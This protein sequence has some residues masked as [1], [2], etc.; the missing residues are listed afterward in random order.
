M[1]RIL[2]PPPPGAVKCWRLVAVYEPAI[3]VRR[4]LERD[5]EE[6][7]GLILRFYRFNEEFDP[8]YSVAEDAEEVARRL[9]EEY[10]KRSDLVVFVADFEGRVVGY[11]KG[12]VRETP[13][14]NVKRL[15]VL[16]E[17]Y[18]LPTHRNMGIAT[19]LI[20]E[21]ASHLSGRGVWYL[22][23]EFPTINYVAERFYRRMGFRPYTSIYLRES[24]R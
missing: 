1:A 8:V 12:E 11:V 24:R 3:H 4:P 22:A 20:E 2:H 16:S 19:K 7:S 14:L 13:M 15:G 5:V 17:L 6:L 18:V 9:A 21:A 23:V 10:V